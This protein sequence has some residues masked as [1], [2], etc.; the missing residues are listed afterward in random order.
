MKNGKV[1]LTLALLMIA[2]SA[3]LVSAQSGSKGPA[4][5]DEQVKTP[6][7]S[8]GNAAETPKPPFNVILI[9][10]D[11]VQRNHLKECIS[12][13]EV[14]NLMK[15]AKKGALMQIDISTGATDTK[16]GWTQILTGYDPERTGVYNN[17]KYQPI[18]EGYSIIERVENRFGPENIVTVFL[19][20]KKNHVGARGPHI[21]MPPARK[22]AKP[23][24]A[25]DADFESRKIVE[26]GPV[27][28]STATKTIQEATAEKSAEPAQAAP[29]KPGRQM[30]GEPHY[31]A[32][33][34]ADLFEN[35]LGAADNVGPKALEALDKYKDQPFFFFV[36]FQE[37]DPQGHAKGENS[38]EY[39]AGIMKDDQWLG[40]IVAKL[41][42]LDLY[43]KTRIYVACD[44]GFDEGLKSHKNAPYVFFATNDP[45]VGKAGDRK[46]LA[47]TILSRLG[48]DLSK[49]EP[50]LDGKPLLESKSEEP[51]W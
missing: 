23:G 22:K 6:H 30:A 46:D 31:Y 25:T 15:L 41:K 38:E 27:K 9:G 19:A 44:H 1:K 33:L 17:A 2:L 8:G 48:F 49:I 21:L 18:P 20:G 3:V 7:Q 50:P 47:P 40:E 14:P 10:W 36:H 29:K 34:H 24:A 42:E 13:N 32:R 12:R 4:P 39:T 35:G 5:S 51:I 45:M 37:P 28:N 11:A 16:A 43:D 26:E